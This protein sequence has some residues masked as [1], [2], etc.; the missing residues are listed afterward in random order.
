[1]GSLESVF[2]SQQTLKP[3]VLKSVHRQQDSFLTPSQSMAY[4]AH[5]VCAWTASGPSYS[6][7][8]HSKEN[9]VTNYF[10]V[11]DFFCVTLTPH[12]DLVSESVTNNLVTR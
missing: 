11:T 5:S 3:K 4:S 8:H 12:S 2:R 7:F 1:M 10:Q 6:D 9:T